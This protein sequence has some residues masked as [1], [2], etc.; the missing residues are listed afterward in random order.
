[1]PGI[2]I[3]TKYIFITSVNITVSKMRSKI[4]YTLLL[5]IH[6]FNF[7]FISP[8]HWDDREFHLSPFEEFSPV[9]QH[10]SGLWGSWSQDFG[11]GAYVVFS[12]LL[13]RVSKEIPIVSGHVLPLNLVTQR[14][15]F[16]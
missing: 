2:G 12:L 1:M 4:N 16:E 15:S 10:M 13:P 14:K 11:G 6:Q 7:D 3:K 5:S 8:S 9:L